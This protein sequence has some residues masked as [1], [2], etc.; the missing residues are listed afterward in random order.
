M[1]KIKY[2][3]LKDFNEVGD[4]D[5]YGIVFDATL[6]SREDDNLSSNFVCALKILGPGHN[7]LT[8]PNTFQDEVIHII[9]KSSS[10]E[11]VP[12]IMTV[13]SIIRVNKGLYRPKKRK[14]IYLN[15]TNISKIKSS[16]IVFDS[17]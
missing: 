10:I 9:V 7:W 3:E 8:H 2:S 6:P 4:Y 14:N 16:W 12:H 1:S 11:L 13:G 17:K 15:L 5:F